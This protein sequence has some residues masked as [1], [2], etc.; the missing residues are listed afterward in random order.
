MCRNAASCK[1]RH[2][3]THLKAPTF[4]NALNVHH[5]IHYF[6]HSMEQFVNSTVQQLQCCMYCE[7]LKHSVVSECVILL[8]SR[9]TNYWRRSV[10]PAIP[11]LVL[12]L[13]YINL[14]Q[15]HLALFEC[16]K[17]SPMLEL[18]LVQLVSVKYHCSESIIYLRVDDTH[19]VLLQ[20]LRVNHS[21]KHTQIPPFLNHTIF[22]SSCTLYLYA[23]TL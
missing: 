11:I 21:S 12:I 6:T 19:L 7:I 14:S 1:K 13:I 22:S 2:T 9:R 20:W 23:P 10:A 8:C 4:C 17:E 16:N 15:S 3:H 18:V 5:Y